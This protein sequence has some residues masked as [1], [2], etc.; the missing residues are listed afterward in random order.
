MGKVLSIFI[1]SLILLNLA[2]IVRNPGVEG[3]EISLYDEYPVYL[4]YSILSCI[5]ICQIILLISFF[6]NSKNS[7]LWKTA[8]IG[9]VLSNSI[10]ILMPLIRGYTIYGYGD[11]CAHIGFIKDML[12]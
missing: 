2:I 12:N 11:P 9:I 8:C 1:F 3:Y 10:L 7:I 4:W 5:F 6:S